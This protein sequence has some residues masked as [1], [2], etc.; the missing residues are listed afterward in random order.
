[1]ITKA[2]RFYK[3]R[4]KILGGPGCGKTTEILK[5]LKRNFEEG[6]HFDQVLM[7]GFA[8]ATVENLQDRAINDKTL[9]LFLTEKQ[10]ESIKTIHKFCKDHLSQFAIFNESAKRTFKDLIKTDPDNWPKLAD[11]NYDGTDLVAVGW[12]EEHDKKFG[13]IM[14][15]IGLAKHSLG[16]EKAYKVNGEYKI[17]KDPLQ[18]KIGRAHV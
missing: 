1:M 12:T 6:M 13:A 11:T 10:A 4:Y 14:N 3:R 17:V 16:F 2:D 18:R 15:L 7:I 8:K 5:M 9:S